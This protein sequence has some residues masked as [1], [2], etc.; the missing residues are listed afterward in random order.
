MEHP[1]AGSFGRG[2]RLQRSLL[3]YIDQ[4][5]AQKLLA[6]HESACNT[7]ALNRIY[8]LAHKDTDHAWLWHLNKHHGPVM[9]QDEYVEALRIR[10]GAAGPTEVVPCALCGHSLMDAAGSNAHCCSRAESTKGHHTVAR[11]NPG[12]GEAVRSIG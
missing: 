3:E 4:R 6:M 9:Q 5:E 1:H 7:P 2:P 10:V 8:D 11:Q 12:C